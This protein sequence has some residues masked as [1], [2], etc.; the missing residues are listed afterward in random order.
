MITVTKPDLPPLEEY[1]EYLK[2]IWKSR[3]LT[4]NG[5]L[6][7]LFERKLREFLKVENLL[8]VVNG[9]LALHCA[10]KALE[11]EGEVITTPFTFPATTNVIIWEG[12]TPVFADIDR[13]TFNIDPEDVERKIT[14]RTCAIIAV[15]T[16]G[17]PCYVEELEEIAEKYNLKIIY[18]A[19]HAFGVEYKGR[20]VLNYGDVSTLSFHATKVFHTIE[21][22]AIVAK[23]NNLFEKLKL[24][25]NHGIKSEEEFVIPGTNAKM[26]EFQAAM[27]LCNLKYFDERVRRRKIIVEYYKENLNNLDVEFQKVIASKHN[28]IYMPVLFKNSKI[29]NKV[30]EEL[31]RSGIK[32]RKYFYP[33]TTDLACFKNLDLVKKFGLKVAPEI[34]GRILCLPLYSDLTLEDVDRVI[35]VIRRTLETV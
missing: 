26:N 5:E 1:V 28:Y 19:A 12:L 20:S 31:S 17:N 10:I 23:D 30:Y 9:T 4:N 2:K 6:L 24:L 16:F 29:R 13:Q 33:L 15:H 3:W 11:L 22:G 8:C 21:G 25:I 34:S 35:K 32:S 18:D 27:G 7:Q 14:E